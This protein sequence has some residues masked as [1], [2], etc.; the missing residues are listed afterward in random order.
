MSARFNTSS[1]IDRLA[2]PYRLPTILHVVESEQFGKLSVCIARQAFARNC[3]L[4]A[5]RDD[6]KSANSDVRM[7]IGFRRY[8]PRLGRETDRSGLMMSAIRR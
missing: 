5:W 2:Q 3:N 8:T 1:G 6:S 7:Y 4:L